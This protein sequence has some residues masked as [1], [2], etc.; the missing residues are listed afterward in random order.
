[1][2]AGP[3]ATENRIAALFA[4]TKNRALSVADIADHAF[5]LAGRPATREQ[6]LS[7][8][9]AAHRLVRRM[10]ETSAWHRRLINDAH[11]EAKAALG[12][13]RDYPDP[14]YDAA[15]NANSSYL[16]AEKLYTFREQFDFWTRYVKVDH[17]SWRLESEE[18]WR[19]T[20]KNRRI[21]FHRPDVPVSIHAVS[22]QPAGVI[23]ADAD[24]C[25]ITERNV[26]VR[27]AGE[28]ARLN[29]ESL[30]RHWAL[31]RGVMFVSSR[32]GRVAQ[33]LDAMWQHRYGHTTGG[34][35]PVMQMPL[36]EA[37]ALLECRRTI[38]KM[39]SMPP[40]AVKRKGPIPTLAAQPSCFAGSSRL[41]TGSLRR[42]A[43]AHQRR[44]LQPMRQ[45]GRTSFIAA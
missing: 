24:I 30:W 17:D 26:T 4:A 19:A 10:K 31:W 1:M 5:E 3:G 20:A 25:R 34:V 27:Y 40:S 33:Q 8:T 39:T 44:S 7:A 14:E 43:Q 18:F 12:R 35:P 16:R 32:T 36:A 13:A 21:H 29:R 42:S 9:R 6:R 28:V 11:R 2:S 41:A 38:P 37:I 15:L 22:I 23:W 45:A